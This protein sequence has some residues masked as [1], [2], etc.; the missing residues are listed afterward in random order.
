MKKKNTTSKSQYSYMVTG[1]LAAHVRN[2]E[3]L[4]IEKIK[5]A[6]NAAVLAF[7]LISEHTDEP[8]EETEEE[9]ETV[10]Y[11]ADYPWPKGKEVRYTELERWLISQG[12][13]S[14]GRA[15]GIIKKSREDGFIVRNILTSRYSRNPAVDTLKD[16]LTSKP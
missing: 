13:R 6:V 7:Q 12:V 4:T 1:I 16:A 3:E 8:E 10:D 15:S 9:L 2:G 11:F 5:K 14:K